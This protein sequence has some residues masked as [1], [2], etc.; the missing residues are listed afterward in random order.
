MLLNLP[1]IFS[2]NSFFI[3]PIIPIFILIYSLS[4]V[5]NQAAYNYKL[6][7]TLN[8]IVFLSIYGP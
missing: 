3:L 6:Q 7:Y 5:N 2:S 1:I 4:L 8:N